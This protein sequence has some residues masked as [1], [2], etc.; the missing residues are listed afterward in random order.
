MLF[1]VMI[2]DFPDSLNIENMLF[3]DDSAIFK[4]GRNLKFMA[5]SLQKHLN[6]IQNWCEEWGFKLSPS[7]TTAVVFSL[8]RV[9]QDIV[10]VLKIGL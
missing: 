9:P 6:V 1:L 10:K 8:K 2:N 7:K 3:A 4:S 5:D